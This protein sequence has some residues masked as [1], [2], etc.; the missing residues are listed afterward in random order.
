[1]NGLSLVVAVGIALLTNMLA[2]YFLSDDLEQPYARLDPVRQRFRILRWVGVL[3][4]MLLLGAIQIHWSTMLVIALLTVTASTDFETKFLPPD[5][6]VYGSTV[7]GGMSACFTHGPIGLR[8]A[9]IAQAFCFAV[10]TLGVALFNL[11]DSG[12]IKLA[13]QFGAACASLPMV[14]FAAFGTWIVACVL[15]AIQLVRN[16]RQ[17]TWRRAFSQAA[18]YRPPQGPLLWGGLMLTV[19]LMQAGGL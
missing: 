11:S 1:M 2:E 12:D 9:V 8:D 6:F 16:K 10:A 7:L 15:F 14:A 4:G 3:V 13:M 17:S 18:L 5:H 19:V